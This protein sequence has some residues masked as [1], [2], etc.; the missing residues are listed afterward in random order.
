V[1]THSRG[2]LAALN[3]ACAAALAS[4]QR[5][6]GGSHKEGEGEG[7]EGCDTSKHVGYWAGLG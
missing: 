1:Y 4:D 3:R 5:C 6:W 2:R 7:G